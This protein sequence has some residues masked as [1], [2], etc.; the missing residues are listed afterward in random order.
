MPVDNP[1]AKFQ[2]A[3]PVF[4]VSDIVAT[5]R[6]YQNFLGF[7]AEA[8]PASPPH[9]FG[10]LSKD[11]V[12]IM[13]QQLASYQKPGLY[14]KR[15]GGVWNVYLRTQGVERLYQALLNEP[16]VKILE[17]LCPQFYGETE[18]VVEDLNG[19]V[20]VFAERLA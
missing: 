6:W 3:H 16:E 13:L 8:F 17:P 11:D 7:E 19:Y 10:I 2:H 20:L 5:M 14:E 15:D 18:F 1:D 9:S 12:V 4:L